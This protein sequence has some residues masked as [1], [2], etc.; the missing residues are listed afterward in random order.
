M[1]DS[2]LAGKIG[3][4]MMSIEDEGMDEIG[5]IPEHARAW[6]ES[7][8]LDLQRRKAKVRCRQNVK[9][10]GWRWRERDVCW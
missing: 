6:G 8:E 4:W 1:Y 2:F 7:I 9:E 3:E 10:G 5:Y